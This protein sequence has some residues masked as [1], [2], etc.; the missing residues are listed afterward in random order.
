MQLQASDLTHDPGSAT[1]GLVEPAW[2]EQHLEDPRLRLVE[3]D[4]SRVRYDEGHIP[5]AVV[6]NV[7]QDLKDS[8]CRPVP[9]SV[10]QPLLE[11]SG[12]APNSIVVFYGYAPA[13]GVWLMNLF[14]HTNARIL[15]CSRE[16]WALEGRPWSTE[17]TA[18][19]E[20]E[21]PLPSQDSRLRASLSTVTS[22][23]G[24]LAWNIVDVRTEA[25]YHGERFW[26]SGGF[27]PGGR[28][29]HIPTAT[30]LP[31]GDLYDGRGAFRSA[32]ELS[33]MFAAIDRT[34]H[35]GVI[36]Y[37][38]IGGRACTA[39]FVLT[40]LLGRRHVRV[41]DGSWAEWGL[42]PTTPVDHSQEPAQTSAARQPSQL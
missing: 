13:M 42:T 21:Y 18:P 40:H 25:E 28:A 36:T 29:G 15:N 32:A 11:N 26:P 12:I 10:V 33:G 1:Y 2:L 20:S 30:S 23:I 39:W 38:T 37:C 34:G 8:R 24:D 27:E 16:S 7:Y 5:G 6:W 9:D 41:Y 22:A 35:P 4:V 3:V 31:I 19:L 14:G 17:Q